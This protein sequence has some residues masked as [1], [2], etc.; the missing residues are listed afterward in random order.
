MQTKPIVIR[1]VHGIDEFVFLPE[2]EE[3]VEEDVHL[4]GS[5]DQPK[6]ETTVLEAELSPCLVRLREIEDQ[7]TLPL[8]R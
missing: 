5:T 6:P 7:Q 3:C 2:R 8:V 4:A 1:N